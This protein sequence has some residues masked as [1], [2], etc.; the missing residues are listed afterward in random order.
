MLILIYMVW[1]ELLAL[2]GAA[3]TPGSAG[4]GTLPGTIFGIPTAPA[5]RAAAAAPAHPK[6]Q[7]NDTCPRPPPSSWALCQSGLDSPGLQGLWGQRPAFT[8]GATGMQKGCRKGCSSWAGLTV[9]IWLCKGRLKSLC[10]LMLASLLFLSFF[11][12]LNFSSL[13]ITL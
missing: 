4:H 12:S 13:L 5:A 7:S 9:T 8:A 10:P 2:I 3:K 1:V 6:V 11:P